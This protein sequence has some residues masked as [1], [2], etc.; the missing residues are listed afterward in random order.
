[1]MTSLKTIRVLLAHE[2]E[3][4]R[5]SL[6][7]A[8]EYLEDIL[9][10]GEA[11]DGLEAVRLCSELQP[12]VILMGI[13]LPRLDGIAATRM[14]RERGLQTRVII[15]TASFIT[16][17]EQAALDAGA[18]LYLRKDGGVDDI[19]AAIRTVAP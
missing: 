15:L 7:I 16:G 2:N 1:M 5:M 12:D 13:R 10:I 14:I 18:N 4:L 11:S 8:L 6:A 9:L 17:D 3:V 19:A